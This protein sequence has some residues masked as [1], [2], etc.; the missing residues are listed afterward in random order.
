[1]ITLSLS[2]NK[3]NVTAKNQ[4]FVFILPMNSKVN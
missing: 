1:M 3:T 4:I 2:N